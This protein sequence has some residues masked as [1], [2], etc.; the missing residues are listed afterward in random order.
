MGSGRVQNSL[1]L[2]GMLQEH[3]FDGCPDLVHRADCHV[4]GDFAAV[5][6]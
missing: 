6:D 1:Q 5:R 3:V 2:S 4:H